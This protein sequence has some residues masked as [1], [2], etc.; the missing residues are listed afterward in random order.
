MTDTTLPPLIQ[1]MQQ[2]EF[3]PHAVTEPIDLIQTHVSYVLLTGDYVYKVKK[4]VNFGFLDFSSLEKRQ[5]FCEEELRLNQRGA[6]GLYLGVIPLTQAGEAF[7]LGGDGAVVEFCVKMRQFPQ[8]ALFTELFD[9]GDLTEELL[10]RLAKTLAE[11]HAKAEITDEVRSYGEV[12]AV[13][14]AIDE[15]YAQTAKYIGIAQTQQHFDETKQYTDRLFLEQADLFSQ[16]IADNWV[17]ECHGDVHLRNIAL[18]NDEILLF[19]CIEFNKPFRFVDVMFDAAYIVMDLDVRDRR[20]LS[21]AFLNAYV[22]Q[23]GDWAGLQVLP[24]Y[25]SRQSYVRAK[26][27]SFLL[28][29]PSV[30][31]SVKQEAAQTAGQ[32]YRLAWEYTQPRQGKLILMAGLSGSGKSTV[33]R[34]FA[35]QHGAIQIRS[36]AVRK[37]LA[38]VALSAKGGDDLYTPEMTERTY[39]RLL[40]LGT[41]LAAQGYT[42]I[43]DAKYDRATHR[44][45]AIAQAQAHQIPLQILHCTAPLEVL[46]ARIQQ[47]QNDISDVTAAIVA[48][49]AMEPFSAEEQALVQT[50]DTA[51]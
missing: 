27:T 44:Q 39:S 21:N 20:D 28:D 42:V 38:G 31:E 43:L 6:A 47:R 37:H 13:K 16:R 11:F 48:H 4:P 2:P 46:Q 41:N 33:A 36:D 50:I 12:E 24:L 23:T 19:D 26:V 8:S 15:N 49:Q 10:Q 34:Q 51:Q 7:R 18:W 40:E 22:E 35:R 29:D 1:Q 25:V 3:Y 5:N 17:R 32:Y 45:A 14:L 30:P 9:R